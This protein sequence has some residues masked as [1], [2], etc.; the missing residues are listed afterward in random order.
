MSGCDL[1]AYAALEPLHA[2]G[3]AGVIPL[4]ADFLQ[5]FFRW[6]FR[7]TAG[8]VYIRE[9]APAFSVIRPTESVVPLKEYIGMMERVAE[10]RAGIH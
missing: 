7:M 6:S 5:C 10:A 4:G 2:H 1:S 9:Q 8:G 3:V